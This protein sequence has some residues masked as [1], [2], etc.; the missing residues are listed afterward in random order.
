MRLNQLLTQAYSL[1]TSKA[2]YQ[3]HGA[4]AEH[5]KIS[6]L[7]QDSRK[8]QAG[9]LFFAIRGVQTD[10]HT[11]IASAIAQGASAIVVETLPNEL[12]EHI[13]YIVVSDSREAMGLI[14]SAWWG[15]PSR[16]VTLVGVT[17]TNGK[18]TIATLLYRLWGQMGYKV[19]LLSTVCNYIGER[20]TPSTHT[21]P[22]ALELQA[23]LREMVDEG[24]TH[25][26]ME[27]SSHAVDQHRIAGLEFDGGIF[28]NLTRDHLDYHGTVREY[29][30]AKKGFFDSLAPAAFAL[31]NIDD[32]NGRVILQN[33]SARQLCYAL[34]APA[35]HKATILEVYPDS[36]LIEID[37][38]EVV[39]RLVGEFNIYNL[40]AVYATTLAL[41]I[42]QAE[43]LR[44]VS[45]LRAVDGRL[46]TF[47]HTKRGYTAFVDYAHTPDALENVLTTIQELRQGTGQIIC[48]VGCGGDRDRGKRP[49]MAQVSARLADKVIL[50]ADNPRSEEVDDILSDMRQGL[51]GEAL[52]RTLTIADR[53]EAIRTACMLAQSG[54][55]I[56]IAG[57]GHETYQE[58]KGIR[59]PFDDR[60]VVRSVIEE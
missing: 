50:T 27:V 7:V 54:D 42:D 23:L 55:Y 53:A 38:R 44:E 60:Q 36:T 37:G 4:S 25:V 48:V 20:A 11:H 22:G 13:A 28:T 19:G 5:I 21:T 33:C 52:N 9:A 29:L 3:L 24:C 8:V 58:I 16:S 1:G 51:E 14:A 32:K 45:T 41:G 31:T 35:D 17:G 6:T 56:L 26:F 30:Y 15:H 43:A 47:R 57:K 12:S 2:R 40:L 46:E 10:G 34:H 49:I 59:H 39:V 18:T